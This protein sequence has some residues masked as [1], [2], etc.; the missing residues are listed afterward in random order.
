MCP[1]V[2]KS[3][4]W[5]TYWH[6]A[7]SAR[8]RARRARPPA[9]VS[10][11]AALARG[12]VRSGRAPSA[13]PVGRHRKELRER[14]A[15]R[16]EVGAGTEA[17]DR[18]RR[19]VGCFQGWFRSWQRQHESGTR[20]GHARP[21]ARG[22]DR[23]PAGPEDA[24]G[25]RGAVRCSRRR[26]VRGRAAAACDKVPGL[27]ALTR[28]C[29]GGCSETAR[30]KRAEAPSDSDAAARTGDLETR[31]GRADKG[32]VLSLDAAIEQGRAVVRE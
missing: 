21:G 13:P 4:L 29:A 32:C 2:W 17:A 12:G 9:L 3:Y 7:A 5:P 28:P 14:S 18:E 20:C 15:K 25:S 27:E 8:G 11:N 6:S 26:K 30:R 16:A 23:W 19:E 31:P 1:A 10:C 22:L 24:P